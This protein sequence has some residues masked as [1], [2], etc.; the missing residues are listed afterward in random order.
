MVHAMLE[1][2]ALQKDLARR[3]QGEVLIDPFDRGLYATD[4]SAYQMMPLAV[5]VPKHETDIAETLDYASQNSIPILPRGGGTSQCGQTVTEGIV[6]DTS[7]HLNHLLDIDP[8]NL[9][10]RVEGGIVLDELNR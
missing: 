3:V 2:H 10:C 1:I 8:D 5:V 6:V 7:R 4:A 9:E